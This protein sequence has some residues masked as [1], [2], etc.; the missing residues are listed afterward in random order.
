MGV[1]AIGIISLT[2]DFGLGDPYVAMMKGVILSVNPDAKL[3]DITHQIA[4]GSIRQAASLIREGFPFFPR[5]SVHVAV[6]D[7]G[8]GSNRRPIGL[9]A[10]GH[11]FVGPDNGVFW[12]VMED[13]EGV[14]IFHLREKR[15]FQSHVSP[16]FHGRDIFAPA[17]A[18]LS[19]GVNLAKM[20]PRIKDPITLHFPRPK[21]GKGLLRGEIT[22]VD[23]FGNLITNIHRRDLV[24]FIG[25]DHPVIKAGSLVIKKL[26]HVYAEA[27]EGETLALLG[28]SDWLEIAVN[29]GRASD[30]LGIDPGEI[31]GT[32]VRLSKLK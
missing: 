14:R 31:I 11:F 4:A 9:E 12:P 22:R 15:F 8:V 6:V 21:K 7:P 10:G 19:R 18:H 29:L 20:G 24:S 30:C 27:E 17:A 1:K 28:S 16:T 26:S 2:T 13:D 23:N 32:E 3:V 25:S 5:G